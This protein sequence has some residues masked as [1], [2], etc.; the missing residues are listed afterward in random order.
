MEGVK[1][2]KLGN[3]LLRG[4]MWRRNVYKIIY[5]AYPN[6]SIFHFFV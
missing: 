6:I 3:F 2:F 1:E 4:A 5:H